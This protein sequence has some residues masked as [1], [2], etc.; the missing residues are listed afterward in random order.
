M[1]SSAALAAGLLTTAKGARRPRAAGAT[2]SCWKSFILGSH[3]KRKVPARHASGL[4]LWARNHGVGK[5]KPRVVYVSVKTIYPGANEARCVP[6]ECLASVS[7]LRGFPGFLPPSTGGSS[8]ERRGRAHA[9]IEQANNPHEEKTGSAA[10]GPLG[11]AV[12]RR[13][14]QQVGCLVL[15]FHLGELLHKSPGVLRR[16]FTIL[17][18]F[19]ARQFSRRHQGKG[20]RG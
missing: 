14:M 10:T 17:L 20:G 6:G 19:D 5:S 12:F 3:T 2:S 13:Q 18:P 4:T 8:S 16:H 1:F 9:Q 11:M 7:Q 15:L